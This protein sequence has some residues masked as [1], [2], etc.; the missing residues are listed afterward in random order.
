MHNRIA[1]KVV[2][3]I[4]EDRFIS[5]AIEPHPWLSGSSTTV[6]PITVWPDGLI[7]VQLQDTDGRAVVA[8]KK[9]F[10]KEHADLIEDIRYVK[11]DGSCPKTISIKTRKE[12]EK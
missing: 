5:T 2:D 6:Y 3:L 7:V 4:R 9:R 10:I 1:E 11:N 8:W 12:N